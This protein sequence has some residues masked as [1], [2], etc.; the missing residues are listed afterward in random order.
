MHHHLFIFNFDVKKF[1]LNTAL[2]IVLLSILVLAIHVFFDSF[3]DLKNEQAIYVWG[4]SQMYYGL[5]LENISNNTRREV[6]SFAQEGSGIYEFLNFVESVPRECTVLISISDPLVL[7][8]RNKERNLTGYDFGVLNEMY[9]EGYEFMNCFNIVMENIRPRKPWHQSVQLLP[10]LDHLTITE[11]MSYYLGFYS[12][13]SED[14][15][16]RLRLIKNGLRRLKEKSCKIIN[17]DFPYHHEL[18]N[19]VE[20]RDVR[21]N[22]AEAKRGI[23]IGDFGFIM[24]SENIECSPTC[25]FDYTHLNGIGA[26]NVSELVVKSLDANNS[27]TFLYIE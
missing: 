6:Y 5:D 20:S 23:F 14:Y 16:I 1:I 13:I 18:K 15:D 10:A 26:K 3:Y 12:R 9:K 4:D 24:R 27:G 8:D 11:P 19:K 21:Q 25:M 22:L 17:I 7:R 2:F